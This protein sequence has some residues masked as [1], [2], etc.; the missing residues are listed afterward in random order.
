MKTIAINGTTFSC[1]FADL[2]PPLKPDERAALLQ[3]IRQRGVAVAVV[4]DELNA[5][6]DGHNRLEIAS[7]LGLPG[8][9]VKVVTGL[10]DDEK[11]ALA[12][13]LNLHRRH[14]SREEVRQVL[15][16]RLKADPAQSDRIV[17]KEVRVDHKTVGAVRRDLEATGEIPQM[18]AT[19]GGD[20]RT[21]RRRL[22]PGLPGTPANSAPAAL[23]DPQPPGE[24]EGGRQKG[25]NRQLSRW[26][27]LKNH[28]SDL[29]RFARDLMRLGKVRVADRN[30]EAVRHLARRI[31]TVADAIDREVCTEAG[32]V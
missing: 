28:G 10:G 16:H 3:D 9:P 27:N 2:L 20:G 5:V 6:L 31:R 7:E 26:S 23:A 18:S 1:P 12:L 32:E 11:R 4:V 17:A 19:R 13:D 14:L 25:A 22:P 21:R 30:P 15:E 29:Q 24:P 8:V